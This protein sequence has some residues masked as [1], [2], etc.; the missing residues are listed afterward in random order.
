ML[1]FQSYIEEH[2]D[3]IKKNYTISCS[4]KEAI[5]IQNTLDQIKVT[6]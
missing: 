2:K 1:H 5:K 6:L 4:Y 3:L